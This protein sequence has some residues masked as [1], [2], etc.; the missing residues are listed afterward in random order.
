MLCRYR[1]DALLSLLLLLLQNEI[2]LFSAYTRFTLY[3][4][5]Y[6]LFNVF[7]FCVYT[8]VRP[9]CNKVAIS[10]GHASTERIRGIAVAVV[11]VWV[12]S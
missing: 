4:Y 12:I 7:S 11:R 9:V 5:D 10:P 6:C 2:Y 8:F 3:S 1:Q